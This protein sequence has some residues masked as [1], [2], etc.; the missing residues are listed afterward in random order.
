M[1]N[2]SILI[3]GRRPAKK[4]IKPRMTIR[5]AH[6]VRKHSKVSIRKC[7]PKC[8]PNKEKS[9]YVKT[10]LHKNASAA[11]RDVIFPLL[12]EDNITKI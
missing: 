5:S 8:A 9:R 2:T 6:F 11:L 12:R 4:Q 1:H 10:D 3:V 7:C